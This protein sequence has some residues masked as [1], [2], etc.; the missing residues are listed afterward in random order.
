MITRRT[1]KLKSYVFDYWITE[2]KD[3]NDEKNIKNEDDL[4]VIYQKKKMLMV[5]L[6][7]KCLQKKKQKEF[8]EKLL[9]RNVN[10]NNLSVN[11]RICTPSL[12]EWLG[13][14]WQSFWKKNM[15]MSRMNTDTLLVIL[16]FS[17]GDDSKAY[18]LNEYN[19]QQV[20][21]MK[22]GKHKKITYWRC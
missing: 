9:L 4:L 11:L 7:D 19:P 16:K 17:N 13:G 21:D 22:C 6:G 18:F 12:N 20:C 15:I 1:K 10:R 2:K 5:M 14:T 3:W 8:Q